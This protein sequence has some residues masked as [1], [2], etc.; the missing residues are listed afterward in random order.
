MA[1]LF[2]YGTVAEIKTEINEEKAN[3]N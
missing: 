1:F 3:F 2:E